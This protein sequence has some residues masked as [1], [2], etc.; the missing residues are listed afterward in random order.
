MRV[1]E[2]FDSCLSQARSGTLPYCFGGCKANRF[3]RMRNIARAELRDLSP[4]LS[5]PRTN[6]SKM[7]RDQNMSRLRAPYSNKQQIQ[8]FRK[9]TE[10]SRPALSMRFTGL[11]HEAH[12]DQLANH[13]EP[14]TQQR[15]RSN[16]FFVNFFLGEPV[17]LPARPL[18]SRGIGAVVQCTDTLPAR[19]STAPGTKI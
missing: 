7:Q 2:H 11:S 6:H 14:G 4:L 8:T 5:D 13:T 9:Q 1:F 17:C 10:T 18:L 19:P 15:L 16:T 3:P 12:L